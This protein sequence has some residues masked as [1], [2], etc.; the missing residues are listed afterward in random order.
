[1]DRLMY[2]AFPFLKGINTLQIS[3]NLND[4]SV[5]DILLGG[6]IG[7]KLASSECKKLE[8]ALLALEDI[9]VE[10]D[11]IVSPIK[12]CWDKE[13]P[14]QEVGIKDKKEA[15]NCDLAFQNDRL[16]ELYLCSNLLEKRYI[17]A[18]ENMKTGSK[19]FISH[20]IKDLHIACALATD[21]INDGFSVF[22]DDWSIDFGEN[23]IS[24]ISEE[25][26]ESHSLVM[27]ISEDYFRSAYCTDEWTS[28]YMR[29]SKTNQNSICFFMKRVKTKESASS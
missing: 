28:F 24:C 11:L 6:R 10:E 22:L 27:L 20:S 16:N 23:I 5:Y 2:K 9:K 26:E 25:I 12:A 17:R 14:P 1:M 3:Q 18:R 19:I 21:F 13:T 15:D 7:L 29:Y 4:R 8:F